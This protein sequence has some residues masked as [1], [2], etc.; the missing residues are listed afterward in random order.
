[1]PSAGTL[2]KGLT[3]NWTPKLWI[4]IEDYGIW[5]RLTFDAPVIYSGIMKPPYVLLRSRAVFFLF[6]FVFVAV[7][8]TAQVPDRLT[9]EQ[10][11][12]LSEAMS[13]PDGSFRSDNLLSNE[14][15]F[16][17][18]IPELLKTARQERVYMGVGPEQNF[19]YIVALKPKMVFI[20]DIRHGN[21][22]VHLMY[23]ALFEMSKDRA[24]FVSRLFS[25]KRL[26]GLSTKSTAI[27]LFEA[28]L[29]VDASKELF[30]ENLKAI[31][32]HLKTKHGFPLSEG[33][34]EGIEWALGNYYRYG[35]S[36]NYNSSI[37]EAAPEIVGATGFGR[38]N[39]GFGNVTYAD[40]MM[41]DDGDGQFRSYLATEENFNFLK[42]LETRNL[43]VPV[44][45]D[46]GGRKA[47]REVAKYLKSVNATVSAFYLSNVEQY[48]SQDGKMGAFMTNIGSLPLDESSTFIRSGNRGFGGGFGRGGLGSEL[49]NM[50][51]ESKV[52]TGR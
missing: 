23:K 14:L 39:G 36:I 37:T 21:L 52:Y 31:G 20:V 38:R 33:D 24:D 2:R 1:M 43:L 27:E 22:D 45:G 19:S 17:Y 9:D 3:E 34:M 13:E 28:Y 5:C 25:R 50:L 26:E 51:S 10:F 49:G 8:A 6:A 30:D 35:P 7:T 12:K 42:D 11:W 29:N 44:V 4:S 41:A 47:I 32:D 48:L 40:L 18:V 16:Q 15:S 46:F